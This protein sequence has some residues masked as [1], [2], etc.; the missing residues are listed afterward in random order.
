MQEC[1]DTLRRRIRM[2]RLYCCCHVVL[3][4]FLR[5]RRPSGLV[6]IPVSALHDHEDLLQ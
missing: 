2:K 1:K 4:Y 5:P 6:G 3:E